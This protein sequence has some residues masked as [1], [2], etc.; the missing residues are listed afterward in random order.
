MNSA[1]PISFSDLSIS[2]SGSDGTVTG[3]AVYGFIS[4]TPFSVYFVMRLHDKEWKIKE[5]YD[6]I[7]DP[8]W[9]WRMFGRPEIIH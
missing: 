1:A 4:S 5:Y 8:D 7:G 3:N 9:A 6:Y 2:E